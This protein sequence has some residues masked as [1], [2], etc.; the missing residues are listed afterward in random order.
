MPVGDFIAHAREWT[1]LSAGELLQACRQPKGV[2][3]VAS[4]QFDAVV[5]A[6]GDSGAA[7][8]ALNGPAAADEQLRELAALPGEVGRATA[9]W[10]EMTS[11]RLVT[12]Y[13]IV[14]LT[15][16]E[17]PTCFCARCARRSSHRELST[18]RAPS[19]Q[20]KCATRCPTDIATNTIRS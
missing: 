10:L 8:S 18:R 7:Q 17:M 6:V 19:S 20:P 15:A 13:D 3:T 5:R 11:H 1:G 14:D 9:A 4:E 16:I 12:G 2:A